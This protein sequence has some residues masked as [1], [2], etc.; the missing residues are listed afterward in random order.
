[1][2]DTVM[3]RYL[4]EI[5]G[6][7]ALKASDVHTVFLRVR[8]PL[9][10]CVNPA[11]AAEIVFRNPRVELIKRQQ[12]SPFHDLEI[13]QMGRHGNAATHPTQR[14]IAPPG[15]GQALGQGDFETDTLTMARTVVCIHARPYQYP[16]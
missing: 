4:G 14:A 9:M 5:E 10:M 11:P 2:H 8:P 1:M 6:T 16:L 13:M 12:I 15:R 7:D 3:H